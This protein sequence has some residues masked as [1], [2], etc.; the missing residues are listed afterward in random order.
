MRIA[1]FGANGATGRLLTRHS[2][3]ACHTV[4]ALLRHPESFPYSDRGN[5]QVIQGSAFDPAAVAR[6]VQGA[7]AVFS[8]LGARSPFRNENVLPRAVPLI[9]SA[10]Q[11]AGVR[12]IIALGSAGARPGAMARQPAWRRWLVENIVYP[13]LL[14][15]PVHEQVLQYRILS[16]SPLDW[17]M[18]MPPM[19]TNGPARGAYR[20]DGEAL[21]RNGSSISRAD[22]A[23]FMLQQLTNAQWIRKGVYITY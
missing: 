21:P 4:T 22:V 10:M 23:A 3:E 18:V 8:A 6:T 5:V 20:I 9:V 13:Y 14:K 11:Q 7:D 1:I 17:T 16:S 15:W 19:L 2:L 12:R